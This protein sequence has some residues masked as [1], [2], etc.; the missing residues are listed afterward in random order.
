MIW[1]ALACGIA[2]AGILGWHAHREWCMRVNLG[3]V[4]WQREAQKPWKE[5]WLRRYPNGSHERH[6][7]P[8]VG[9]S[10]TSPGRRE[11]YG[12]DGTP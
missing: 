8:V 10:R 4:L 2:G 1:I 11:P 9:I 6:P 12:P 5:K 7:T 3:C